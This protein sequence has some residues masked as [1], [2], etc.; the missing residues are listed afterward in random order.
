MANYSLYG[1]KWGKALAGSAAGVVTW[2]LAHTPARMA[3]VNFDGYVAGDSV[4]ANLIRKAFNLWESVA[5]IDFRQVRDSADSDIRLGWSD[6]DGPYNT[7]GYAYVAIG[8]R[9]KGFDS[10]V[11]A[12]IEFDRAE[13]WSTDGTP[14]YGEM[15]FHALAVHEIGHAIGIDHSPDS[16]AVMHAVL[17][18]ENGDLTQGDVAAARAIY[19]PD[20]PGASLGGTRGDDT[21]YLTANLRHINAFEGKDTVVVFG[22]SE[23]FTRKI[24]DDGRIVLGNLGTGEVDYL[25]NVERIQFTNGTLATDP[26]GA[27]AQTYRLYQAAFDRAPDAPGLSHW[28]RLLDEGHLTLGQSA[29]LFTRTA[30]FTK[31]YGEIGRLPDAEF[32]TLLYRNVLDR[33]PEAAGR[34]HWVEVAGN[35]LPRGDML[36][37]FSESR[38]NKLNVQSA[39]EDGIWLV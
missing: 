10:I 38:E 30:E 20:L 13:I 34:A 2:S 11:R 24:N 9:Q 17:T 16:G 3:G 19:G 8:Q 25:D 6:I 29:D 39:I 32:V 23:N 33:A 35:G 12:E 27:A 5:N 4:F 22:G 15:D 28:T 7:L 36:A 1:A 26:D 14:G 31:S 37:G 18:H 21:L